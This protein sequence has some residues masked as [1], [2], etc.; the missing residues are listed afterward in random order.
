MSSHRDSDDAGEHGQ[1]RG[2]DHCA[3]LHR[4]AEEPLGKPLVTEIQGHHDDPHPLTWVPCV[5]VEL[6][7]AFA[8]TRSALL[9]LEE[10]LVVYPEV[11]FF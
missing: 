2:P 8:E 9:G 5:P 6:A 10:V 4:F 1:R 7:D 11:G 3:L